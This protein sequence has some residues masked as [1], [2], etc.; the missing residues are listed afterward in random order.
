M[1]IHVKQVD[2]NTGNRFNKCFGKATLLTF[3]SR[4]H[5]DIL[6]LERTELHNFF[7][8]TVLLFLH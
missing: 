6:D 5:V 2:Q 4:G 1:G 8:C 7:Y 3:A